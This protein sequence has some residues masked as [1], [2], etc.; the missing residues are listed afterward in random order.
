M[1]KL[2]LLK[3]ECMK[4]VKAE[5][6]ISTPDLRSDLPFFSNV[7]E[8]QLESIFPADD[9]AVAVFSG[10]GLRIRLERGSE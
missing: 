4:N 1:V 5:I 6:V 3:V 9:P 2:S 10:H 7:L 8:M